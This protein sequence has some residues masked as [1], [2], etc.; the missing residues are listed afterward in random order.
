MSIPE[1]YSPQRD[2]GRLV[3]RFSPKRCTKKHRDVGGRFVD[4]YIADVYSAHRNVGRVS[5]D[6]YP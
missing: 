1:L 5:V 6:F 2:V 4:V 3:C